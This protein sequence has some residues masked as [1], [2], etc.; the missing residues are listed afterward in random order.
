M[1]NKGKKID[2]CKGQYHVLVDG[3]FY[4]M[5]PP[6]VVCSQACKNVGKFTRGEKK[7]LYCM[8]HQH[9]CES[10]AAV[11]ED[12]EVKARGGQ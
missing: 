6:D 2:C 9:H 1:V 7:I 12:S 8:H 5:K 11:Q 10:C 3:T 4:C